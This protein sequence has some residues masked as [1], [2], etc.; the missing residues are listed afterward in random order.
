MTTA[1]SARVVHSI[2]IHDDIVAA[3]RERLAAN[4]VGNADVRAAD[5]FEAVQVID[6]R[7]PHSVLV[8]IFTEAGIGTKITA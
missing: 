5:A 4:G 3:A 1:A 8:E 6:G 2:D 7:I